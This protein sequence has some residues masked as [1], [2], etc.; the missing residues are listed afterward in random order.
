MLSELFTSSN[1][2]A[3]PGSRVKVLFGP[4]SLDQAHQTDE[5]VEIA[6]L[7]TAARAYIRIAETLLG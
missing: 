7:A 2:V 5:H 6:D 4:G 3:L 1:P